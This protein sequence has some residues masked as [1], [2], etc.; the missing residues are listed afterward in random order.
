MLAHTC[1]P[2]YTGSVVGGS[3]SE[4]IPRQKKRDPTKKITNVKSTVVV[5]QVVECLPIKD[6]ALSSNTSKQT[7]KKSIALKMF[8]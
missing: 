5:A 8:N 2:Q 3:Q 4:A 1:E 7:N 6:E